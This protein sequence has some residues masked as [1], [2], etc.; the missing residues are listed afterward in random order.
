MKIS[1]YVEYL[2]KEKGMSENTLKAYSR[3]LSNFEKV[4]KQ[5]G[6]E[7]IAQAT[8]TDIVAYLLKLKVSGQSPATVNRKLASLRMYY[9]FLLE[10]NMI[11]ENPTAG[12]KSPK[13]ERKEID[14][15]SIEEMD[16][17]LSLPE[18][19]AKGIRDRA[20]LELM[21]ATGLRVTEVIK[22]QVSDIN[23]RVGFVSCTGEHGKARVVP[24]GRP[25][26]A[27]LEEYIYD[28]RPLFLKGEKNKH[29]IL[30]VNYSGDP[31]SRQ[32]LWKIL[33]EYSQKADIKIKLTPQ[34][35]RNS[36]AIHMLQNGADVKALQELLGNEDISAI[37]IYVAATK[38][39]IKD[40]YDRTHPRA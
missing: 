10:K 17:L 38:S 23:L 36:F 37:Q 26:R 7:D 1:A 30:F 15:L 5:Q 12:I 34:T 24:L 21:Y 32:G 9:A 6:V 31:L 22:I 35:M 4:I 11:S 14:F 39:R 3:D 20:I 2:K 13:I 16:R 25:A 29:D 18:K 19:T 28:A 27:A 8:N 40:V 33:K